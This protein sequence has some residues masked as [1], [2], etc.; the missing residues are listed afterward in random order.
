MTRMQ[1]RLSLIAL[2]VLA[3]PAALVQA[4][5]SG[6]SRMSVTVT[7]G[8]GMNTATPPGVP[9]PPANHHVLPNL[10]EIKAG[11]AVNFA[12]A[13]F[14]QI[15]VYQPGVEA[16]D[17]VAPAFPPNLFM[18]YNLGTAYY[19]GINP[20]NANAGTPAAGATVDNGDNRVEAVTF[21][22]PGVYLVVCNVTP[23]FNDGMYAYVKVSN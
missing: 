5:S 4:Q 11:G 20:R 16:S 22:T 8:G 19:V 7:F 3:L 9:S 15:V 17:I 13:G 2:C 12:V 10:I 6:N 1:S 18:N 21:S 14:H 23:H